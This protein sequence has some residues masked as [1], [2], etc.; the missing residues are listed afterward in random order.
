MGAPAVPSGADRAH[1]V[2]PGLRMCHTRRI[3]LVVAGGR[4]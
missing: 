3:M 4:R 1:V 2:A